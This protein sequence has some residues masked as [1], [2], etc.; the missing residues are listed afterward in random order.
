MPLDAFPPQVLTF[1][2]PD[3]MAS[4]LLGTREDL[5]SQ[6][7]PFHGKVF[8][9]P[10][11]TKVVATYGLPKAKTILSDSG[12]SDGFIE[13]QIWDD[14]HIWTFLSATHAK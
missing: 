5:K 2:Y 10:E 1:T 4:W 7:R 14:R 13:A 3:S 6:R 9:L 11:I 8:T 12:L